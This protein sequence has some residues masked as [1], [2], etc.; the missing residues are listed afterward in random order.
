MINIGNIVAILL[1]LLLFY[2]IAKFIY[3][4]CYNMS[5]ENLFIFN[6]KTL[7]FEEIPKKNF[8]NYTMNINDIVT[9]KYPMNSVEENDKMK[10]VNF[11]GE[12]CAIVEHINEHHNQSTERLSDLTPVSHK[13][14]R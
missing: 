10:I 9:W 11:Y 6:N 14:I 4:K 2:I 1:L 5:V 3:I 13:I 12:T 7:D 8:F